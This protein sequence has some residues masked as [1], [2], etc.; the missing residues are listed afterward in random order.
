[1]RG[2]GC[3]WNDIND[4]HFDSKVA[5]T[6]LRPI[7]SGQV[8]T[9]KAMAWLLI[10][11]TLSFIILLTFN[12]LA[13]ILGIISILPVI[14]YPFAKRFTWWPQ[15]FLGICFNWGVLISFAAHNNSLESSVVILYVAGI[16]WTIFYDTIYA[17][18]DVEDDA[19]IGL[20]STA[21][22]F[23]EKAKY[24]LTFFILM[25]FILIN[26]AFSLTPTSNL[27][28]EIMLR[29]GATAFCIHLI[30]QLFKFE[31]TNSAICLKLFRSNKSA[32]LVLVFFLVLAFMAG[33]T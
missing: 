4:Q 2:A 29:C 30:W 31:Q 3:T 25:I 10:Q 32:G 33:Q 17:F 22:L 12:K 24:W 6:K 18:Q 8:S 26:V 13:I 14:I 28:S 5:R 15:L 27:I 21:L 11:V 7:P 16:F 20:K 19:L 23:G 9:K 1:M